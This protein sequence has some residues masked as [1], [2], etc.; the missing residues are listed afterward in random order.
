[1]NKSQLVESIAKEADINKSEAEKIL[2]AITGAIIKNLKKAGKIQII[3]FGSFEVRQRA[4]RMGRN[5]KTG[6]A[7]KIKASKSAAF[8]AGKS[9]KDSVN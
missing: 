2:N 1:M 3:G 8:V 4:A 6:A 5:P 7:I 9:L